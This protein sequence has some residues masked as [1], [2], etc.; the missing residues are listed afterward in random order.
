MITQKDFS[1]YEAHINLGMSLQTQ[2][3][4]SLSFTYF[5]IVL[6]KFAS[7]LSF[8]D[9]GPAW[10]DEHFDPS[11]SVCTCRKI[12]MYSGWPSATQIVSR[13]TETLNFNQDLKHLK[14]LHI[15][16]NEYAYV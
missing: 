8:L 11:T 2:C 3:Q 9:I 14:K 13:S 10:W 15:T 7:I 1:K 5:C 12:L 4:M 6:Q 16:I